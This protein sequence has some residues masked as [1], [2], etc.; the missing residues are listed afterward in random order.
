M[1]RE[2]R[3]RKSRFSRSRRKV[4]PTHSRLVVGAPLWRDRLWH[5]W[6]R[7]LPAMFRPVQ[8]SIAGGARCH[9]PDAYSLPASASTRRTQ[10]TQSRADQGLLL[11]FSAFF[12]LFLC[13]LCVPP[14]GTSSARVRVFAV[15]TQGRSY[16]G[17]RDARSLVRRRSRRKVASTTGVATQGRS[18]DS[19]RDT[20]SL[21]RRRSRRKVAPTTENSLPRSVRGR[22]KTAP[23]PFVEPASGGASAMPWDERRSG[24]AHRDECRACR[25]LGCVLSP[26]FPSCPSC[27][28]PQIHC[29]AHQLPF[30][31]H[32]FDAA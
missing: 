5:L 24:R 32:F 31:P 27:H 12:L 29:Q 21:L 8:K 15:A 28:P 17:G 23:I 9:R 13:V 22:R 25:G 4:A 7:A 19:G 10:R 3:C 11:P 20:R 18:Y 16:D 6:E 2:R 26:G 30:R 14:F 1:R